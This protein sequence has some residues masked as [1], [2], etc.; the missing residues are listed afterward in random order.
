[1]WNVRAV[2]ASELAVMFCALGTWMILK[3]WKRSSRDAALI[4]P[5]KN[6]AMLI[7]SLII[8]I[9]SFQYIPKWWHAVYWIIFSIEQI[10]ASNSECK[11]DNR[12]SFFLNPHELLISHFILPNSTIAL[13]C[14]SAVYDPSTKQ[15]LYKHK[16]CVSCIWY[17]GCTSSLGFDFVSNQDYILFGNV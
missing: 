5:L 8:E 13:Y 17:G 12:L 2:L 9:N 4:V 6:M 1:M 15:I 7:E 3:S 16:A 10:R 14:D 11:G